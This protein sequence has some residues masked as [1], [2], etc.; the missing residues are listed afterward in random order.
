[1]VAF[2]TVFVHKRNVL[3]VH[4]THRL[5][6]SLRYS[7]FIIGLSRSRNVCLTSFMP[8]PFSNKVLRRSYGLSSRT[9]A[10]RSGTMAALFRAWIKSSLEQRSPWLEP[11][12]TCRA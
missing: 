11:E 4:E 2:G 7:A 8:I 3:A 12:S 10:I 9:S 1:M 6:M 5:I